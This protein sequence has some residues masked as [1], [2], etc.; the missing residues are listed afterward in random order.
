MTRERS[1][2]CAR[3]GQTENLRPVK[4]QRC[5]VSE[6]EGA[7]GA[8]RV[9]P[10]WTT[11]QSSYRYRKICQKHYEKLQ[12]RIGWFDGQFAWVMND[13]DPPRDPPPRRSGGTG[14]PAYMIYGT[15][16]PAHRYRRFRG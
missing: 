16:T 11:A 15:K 10:D 5:A 13:P 14:L 2:G 4:L 7:P 1:T 8:T 12:K 9:E 6:A 3:C